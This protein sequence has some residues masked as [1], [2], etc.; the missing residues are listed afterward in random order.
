MFRTLAYTTVFVVPQEFGRIPTKVSSPG[1]QTPGAGRKDTNS[2]EEDF[3]LGEKI[4]RWGEKTSGWPKRNSGLDRWHA[5]IAKLLVSASF[6][7]GALPPD[8]IASPTLVLLQGF[9]AAAVTRPQGP[10]QPRD[11]DVVVATLVRGL[12]P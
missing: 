4:R 6:P 1:E 7:A 2:T 11:L 9:T 3:T 5:R 10:P 12:F 8:Q